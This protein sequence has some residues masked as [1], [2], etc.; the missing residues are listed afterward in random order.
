M[1]HP[2]IAFCVYFC[3]TISVAQDPKQ[4]A[5]TT[6]PDL[7]GTWVFN[8]SKSDIGSRKGSPLYDEL[9]LTILHHE[10]EL[11]IIRWLRK[12]KKETTQRLVY[13]TDKRGESESNNRRQQ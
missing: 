12:K 7:S 5:V 2:L 11:Q 9:T 13:Y 4:T 1:N 6:R 10:P 8:L 3:L